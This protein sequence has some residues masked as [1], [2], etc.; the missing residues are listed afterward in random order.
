LCLGTFDVGVNIEETIRSLAY[1]LGADLCGI[2]PVERFDDAPPG[3]RPR[4]IFPQAK[5]VV[6]NG[7]GRRDRP[8][9]AVVPA[10]EG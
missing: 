5:S 2:A 4:D 8:K 9:A 1:D 7:T 3:F 6:A 10:G